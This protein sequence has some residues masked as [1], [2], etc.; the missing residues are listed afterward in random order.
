MYGQYREPSDDDWDAILT[1]VTT[2]SERG[3]GRPRERPAG[4]CARGSR[5]SAAAKIRRCLWAKKPL[6][7]GAPRVAN[8]MKYPDPDRPRRAGP[9]AAPAAPGRHA[10]RAGR[11]DRRDAAGPGRARPRRGGAGVRPTRAAA[12]RGAR[13]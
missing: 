6:P 1:T 5:M 9:T 7:P 3:G 8:E 13:A 4:A 10:R 2:S 12:I 11:A